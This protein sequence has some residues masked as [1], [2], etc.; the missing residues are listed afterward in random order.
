VK[1]V[2]WPV[3]KKIILKLTLTWAWAGVLANKNDT[4][5]IKTYVAFVLPLCSHLKQ[6]C[7]MFR[8]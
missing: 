7:E 8:V 4:S 2:S 5:Y 3:K 6:E 1:S